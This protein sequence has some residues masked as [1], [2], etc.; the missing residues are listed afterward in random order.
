[1]EIFTVELET[2]SSEL[3]IL[4]FYTV[5]TKDFKQFIRKRDNALKHLCKPTVGCLCSPTD[6]LIY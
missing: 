4:S 2:E 5:H 6:A 3:I 1:L